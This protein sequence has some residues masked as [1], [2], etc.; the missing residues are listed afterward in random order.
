MARPTP[1]ASATAVPS[2]TPTPQPTP[3]VPSATP[4]RP[5]TAAPKPTAPARVPPT[6]RPAS[7]RPTGSPEHVVVTSAS[8]TRLVDARLVPTGLDPRGV[9]A[10]PAGV[11][12]WYDEP[13]WPEP[14]WPGAAILA[15]HIN[16]RRNGPDTF[17][18]LPE[19]GRGAVVTVGYSSGDE[20]DFVVTRSK[21]VP[22]TQTPRDDTI[23]D[24]AN[25]RP[26][27]RLITCDPTTPIR[28]GH[29]QGNWVV[30]ASPPA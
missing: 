12:G 3:R 29:Y 6:A 23:W 1:T 24:A 27:L 28:G 11:A 13:G 26:L 4:V 17:A 8:G 14:G 9:L 30:W 16:T 20:V 19:V 21:A 25:P 15:G 10:P 18:R 22:K 2:R 5:P 7:H